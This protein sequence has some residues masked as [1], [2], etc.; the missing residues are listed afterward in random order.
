MFFHWMLSLQHFV[1]SVEHCRVVVTLAAFSTDFSFDVLDQVKFATE[2]MLLPDF[3]R[4][5]LAATKFAIHNYSVK[6]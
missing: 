4:Y 1:Y 3:S 6:A 5:G 2:P